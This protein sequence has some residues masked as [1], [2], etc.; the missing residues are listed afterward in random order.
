MNICNFESEKNSKTRKSNTDNKSLIL[1]L[2]VYR[3][4]TR[5][6]DRK[7]S[8]LLSLVYQGPGEELQGRGEEWAYFKI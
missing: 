1:E 6:V 5:Y 3:Y 2:F 7:Y 4:F 8:A